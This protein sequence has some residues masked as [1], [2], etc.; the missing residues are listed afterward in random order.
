MSLFGWRFQEICCYHY[1]NCY[2]HYQNCYHYHYKNQFVWMKVS[3]DSNALSDNGRFLVLCLLEFILGWCSIDTTSQE[4]LGGS[5]TTAWAS[6]D[7]HWSFAFRHCPS[8]ST[9]AIISPFSDFNGTW[10]ML[11]VTDDCDSDF[12]TLSSETLVHQLTDFIENA[13]FVILF[14]TFFSWR[15]S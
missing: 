7:K 4:V 3:R 2:R 1:Q 11:K 10:G 8:S 13:F 15:K 5:S 12:S 9:V 14:Y 6:Y